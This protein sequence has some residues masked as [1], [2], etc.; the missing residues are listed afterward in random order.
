MGAWAQPLAGQLSGG[1]L[2]A[3]DVWPSLLQRLKQAV[4]FLRIDA[5]RQK[6]VRAVEAAHDLDTSTLSSKPPTFAN[7][8][9]DT[10]ADVQSWFEKCYA[11][12]CEVGRGDL[13]KG[14]H[15][16]AA[17]RGC[18]RTLFDIACWPH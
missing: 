10:M 7:W 6:L 5:H 3:L 9:W 11:T 8:R 16:A 17:A 1:D 12:L 18:T 4:T 15:V 14:S 13:F 2:S